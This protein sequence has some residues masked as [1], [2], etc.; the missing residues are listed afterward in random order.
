MSADCFDGREFACA[1]LADEVELLFA[2][3]RDHH[4]SWRWTDRDFVEHIDRYECSEAV[5]RTMFDAYKALRRAYILAHQLD[6]RLGGD[7]GD[8][9]MARNIRRDLDALEREAPSYEA[10]RGAT[11]RDATRTLDSRRELWHHFTNP[12][13]RTR[14]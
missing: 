5:L 11:F 10:R 12:Q 7:T 13:W 6:L 9:S 3:Y 14:L 8:D 2:K 4:I 1:N